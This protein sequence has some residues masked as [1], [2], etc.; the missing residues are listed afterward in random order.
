MDLGGVQ[1]VNALAPEVAMILRLRAGGNCVML[2]DVA[3][4][5][6]VSK[7]GNVQRSGGG[8]VIIALFFAVLRLWRGH[9]EACRGPSACLPSSPF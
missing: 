3:Q 6:V 5:L 8:Y 1:V 9:L 4:A 7:L 2:R